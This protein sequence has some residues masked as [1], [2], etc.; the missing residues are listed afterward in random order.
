M[1][2]HF[3]LFI[4]TLN[5]ALKLKLANK[6]KPVNPA[7]SDG[8]VYK[9]SEISQKCTSQFINPMQSYIN[10]M[11][12]KRRMVTI[13]RFDPWEEKKDYIKPTETL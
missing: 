1:L 12:S 5:A 2:I 11:T 6:A 13:S 10:T 7:A 8:L 4:V 9:I 3:I